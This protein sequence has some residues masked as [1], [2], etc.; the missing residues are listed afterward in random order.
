MSRRADGP[1]PP[2]NVRGTGGDPPAL[3]LGRP[4][5]V[6]DVGGFRETVEAAGCGVVVPPR[7]PGAIAEALATLLADPGECRRLGEAARV[8]ADG[9]Y[10]W[11]RIAARTIDEVYARPAG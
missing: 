1:G 7:D 11:A 6:T 3:A 2:G 10:S 5:V 4:L 9:P 8:A